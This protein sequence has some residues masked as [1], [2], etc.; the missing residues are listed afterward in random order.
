MGSSRSGRPRGQLLRR[1]RTNSLAVLLV[2]DLVVGDTYG[3][4]GPR[5]I[6]VLGERAQADRAKGHGLCP[7]A[8]MLGVTAGTAGRSGC[9]RLQTPHVTRA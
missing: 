9:V 5:F 2:A 6:Y 1:P 8:G 3:E 4:R 7:T